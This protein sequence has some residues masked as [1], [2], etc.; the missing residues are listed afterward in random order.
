MKRTLLALLAAT[1]ALGACATFDTADRPA[2]RQ[3]QPA[4][5]P[6]VFPPPQVG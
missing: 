4:R 3:K 5:E 6:I 2:G 1:F